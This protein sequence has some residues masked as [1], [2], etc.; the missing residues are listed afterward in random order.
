MRLKGSKGIRAIAEQSHRNAVALYQS[1]ISID[2]VEPLFSM[3]FFHEFAIKIT[4]VN[5]AEF[6]RMM[7]DRY[8]IDAGVALSEYHSE[9][10][11]VLLIAVTET[12]TT[13]DLQRYHHA[14]LQCLQ[15]RV[16]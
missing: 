4:G 16:H 11:E 10:S 7:K 12:K 6:I 9:H 8:A 3:P 13:E 2:G 5:I 14:F 1:L 15:Q